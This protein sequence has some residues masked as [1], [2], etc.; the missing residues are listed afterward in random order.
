MRDQLREEVTPRRGTA[1]RH[2]GSPG[3]HSLDFQVSW[4]IGLMTILFLGKAMLCALLIIWLA[5]YLSSPPQCVLPSTLDSLPGPVQQAL[6]ETDIPLEWQC[7]QSDG[8]TVSYQLQLVESTT[9]SST[10][11]NVTTTIQILNVEV[12]QGEKDSLA[13]GVPTSLPST[14][15]SSASSCACLQAALQSSQCFLHDASISS[16]DIKSQKVLEEKHGAGSP[17]HSEATHRMFKI[18]FVLST[19]LLGVGLAAYCILR[20]IQ[21]CCASASGGKKADEGQQA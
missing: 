12:T 10:M 9:N 6:F 1:N 7:S 17:M 18:Y 15:L 16:D 2:K 3:Q 8:W 11:S 5:Q 19:F 13:K 21:A 20:L 4:R 14:C